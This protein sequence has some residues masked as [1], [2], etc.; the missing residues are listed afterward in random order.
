M[1]AAQSSTP[2]VG[3]GAML[4]PEPAFWHWSP[5]FCAGGCVGGGGGV[6][7]A[8]GPDGDASWASAKPLGKAITASR[9]RLAIAITILRIDDPPRNSELLAPRWK[10]AIRSSGP[11]TAR[12]PSPRLIAADGL[13]RQRFVRLSTGRRHTCAGGDAAGVAT[14]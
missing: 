8:A 12:P 6:G 3:A 1:P 9:Q 11:S 5:R 4:A 13:T 10:S 2:P 7:S 14:A